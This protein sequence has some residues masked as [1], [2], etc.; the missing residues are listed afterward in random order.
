M[1]K[2][3][4]TAQSYISAILGEMEQRGY[5][6]MLEPDLKDWV[7][8]LERQAA[9]VGINTAFDP[10]H[11]PFRPGGEHY[12]LRVTHKGEGVACIAFRMFEAEEGWIDLLKSGRLF[13]QYQTPLAFPRVVHPATRNYFGR[14]G[15][16]GGLW[17]R[18]DHRGNNFAY[19]LTH[20]IRARSIQYCNV[21]HHCGIVFEDLKSSGLPTRNDGYEYERADLS[22]EGFVQV[23]GRSTRM[24]TTYISRP[25]MLKQISAGPNFNFSKPAAKTPARAA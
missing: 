22:I 24:Y 5:A 17:V 16:H 2:S 7:T 21:D 19:L 1:R 23:I 11:H 9:T 3:P 8:F 18:P 13:S 25:T 10:R 20:M 12:W 15:H 6:V 4:F 14:I